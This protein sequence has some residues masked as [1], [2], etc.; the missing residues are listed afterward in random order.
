MTTTLLMT[1]DELERLP[2][3]DHRYV[4]LRGELIRM[5]PTGGS[6]GQMTVR[7]IRWLDT[8]VADHD[9]GVVYTE[10]GFVLEE[11][12][13]VVLAPDV[14]FVRAER[15]PTGAAHDRFLRITPDLAVEVVS[16]SDSSQ[17]VQEKVMTYLDAGVPLVVEVHPRRRTLTVWDNNRQGRILTTNDA[18]ESGDLLPGFSLPVAELFR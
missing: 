9:L 13:D 1:A 4:L 2:D 11:D 7:F 14:A 5:S 6:H 10:T 16:P 15:V 18:F 12:P 3:D 8:F 17:F